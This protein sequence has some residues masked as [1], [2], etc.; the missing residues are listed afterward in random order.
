[1][2]KINNSK[3]DLKEEV[4][5]SKRLRVFRRKGKELVEKGLMSEEDYQKKL[6]YILIEEAER[7]KILEILKEGQCTISKISDITG[8]DSQKIVKHMIALM[9]N[10]KI[11]IVDDNEE[12]Y[13][14][15]IT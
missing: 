14:Y 8:I 4:S 7:R 15:K 3:Y 10:R 11:A 13:I 6:N 9:K 2:E 12:E 5:Y 1:M